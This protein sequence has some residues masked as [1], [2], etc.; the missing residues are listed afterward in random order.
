MEVVNTLQLKTARTHPVQIVERPETGGIMCPVKAYE[1]WRTHRNEPI[2]GGRPVYTW[3][4]GAIV[5]MGDINKMMHC[6]PGRVQ[7]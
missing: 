4:C 6:Y 7:K 3:A 5:T 1:D 2:I